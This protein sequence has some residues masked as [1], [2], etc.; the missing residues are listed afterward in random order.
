MP[1]TNAFL[2]VGQLTEMLAQYNTVIQENYKIIRSL[3]NEYED[4][5]DFFDILRRSPE[6][7][8][9]LLGSSYFSILQLKRKS[10]EL[11]VSEVGINSVI[12]EECASGRC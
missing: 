5:S 9:C 10:P 1:K 7:Q 11:L 3:D 4:L 12:G 6:G 8:K 2:S